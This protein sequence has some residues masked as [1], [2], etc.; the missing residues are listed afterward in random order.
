M[1]SQDDIFDALT[2]H[3]I[4]VL[5]YAR[6][7]ELEAERFIAGTLNEVIN[8]LEDQPLTAFGRA[9]LQNQARDLY[10][11]LNES[12]SSYAQSLKDDMVR[13]GNYEAGFNQSVL[14]NNLQVD[15]GIPSP[16]QIQQA[17]FLD[18]M[19]LEPSQGYTLGGMVDEF[20]QR[21]ANIIFNTIRQGAVLG[22]TTDDLIRYIREIEPMQKRKAATL[23]RTAVNHVAVQARKETLKENDDVL[24]GY[25]WVATL[26]SRTSLIC[27]SRDGV[28]YKDYD[29]DPK[30]PAHFNCRS[31]ITPVVN[32]IYDLGK[33]IVGK[34]PAKGSA[35]TKQ[36]SADVNY[37]D[38]LKR[39]SSGFQDKVLGKGRAKLFRAGMPLTKFVDDR[40]RTLTL[41]ELGELDQDFNGSSVQGI[42][43]RL[44]A[45][46]GPI[47]PETPKAPNLT[48]FST[49][50]QPQG[51][52]S[53]TPA[54][55]ARILEA[56]QAKTRLKNWVQNNAKDERHFTYTRFSG[57]SY[58]PTGDWKEIGKLDDDVARG[59]ES[60][61]DDM[62]KL[63]D[64]F[65]VPRLKGILPINSGSTIANMGD[66]TMGLNNNLLR[67][68]LLGLNDKSSFATIREVNT[69]T[70]KTR[71]SAGKSEWAFGR[72]WTI[73]D[74]L[75]NDYDR[76]RSTFFHELGHHIHQMYK[77]QPNQRYF[78]KNSTPIELLMVKKYGKYTTSKRHSPSRYG[79]TNTKEWFA[80][81]FSAYFM[82]KR[83][84]VDDLFL[85]LIEDMMKGAYP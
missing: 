11:Y 62:D 29:N 54:D 55:Q 20:G 51:E 58:M 67:R 23:A 80:E 83:D 3:Q 63:C 56:D 40:G 84:K 41:R 33:D 39:Q 45:L 25:E 72:P 15:I 52:V 38:W 46:G 61:I 24:L 75:D 71:K 19:G 8:R 68:M 79:D 5:R 42:L 65:N 81:N 9:R 82:N 57:R 49:P 21:N 22:D 76:A 50:A 27:M 17:A 34:R 43:D 77:T 85:D 64:L 48:T 32:P 53:I 73:D 59:F 70:K 69:W 13:F 78:G 31:T 10:E 37:N 14:K 16:M 30:P 60:C 36:V 12:G 18:V 66:S 4:F 26:D 44:D 47:R 6:G 35:G 2:R 7:R 74:F 1:S 28:I